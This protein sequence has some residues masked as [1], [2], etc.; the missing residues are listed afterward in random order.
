MEKETKILA[1]SCIG[2][3]ITIVMAMFAGDFA[4]S[5]NL[6]F[7][8][9]IILITPYT[10]YKFFELKKIKAYEEKFPLFL[11]DMAESQRS[12]LST[13]DSI[14]MAAKSDY[15]HLT[16][17]IKKI[18]NQLSWNIQLVKVLDNFGKR[19][20]KSRTITRSL[21]IIDQANKS[22]GNIEE[23]MEALADNIE[24]IKDVQ[25]EKEALLSQQVMM[26][27]AIFLIFLGISIM[28]IKFL[29]PMLNT[30]NE[31]QASTSL[32]MPSLGMFSSSPCAVCLTQKD[33][34]CLSCDIFF[35]ISASFGFGEREDPASYYK[36]LFFAMIVIQGMLSGLI[37]GQ[38]G[39]ES[40]VAG[41]KH[42]IIMLLIGVFSFMLVVKLGI[43]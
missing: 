19:M 18:D 13:V 22:G 37:V 43:V 8:G 15:G 23:T 38:I 32:G 5:S 40:V 10:I 20:K 14:H 11:R 6:G 24:S 33:P 35:A 4:I 34:A 29:I 31:M 3:L 42:S 12:G 28:L 21:M 2:F 1:M 26:M 25:E 30:Q 39:S 27:Y 16:D 36:S 7:I 41:V 9:V 17:E